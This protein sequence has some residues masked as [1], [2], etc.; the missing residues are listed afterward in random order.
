[1]EGAAFAVYWQGEL[2]VDLWNGYADRSCN[3]AWTTDTLTTT[4]STTKVG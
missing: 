2:V 1:L 3:R 4:F